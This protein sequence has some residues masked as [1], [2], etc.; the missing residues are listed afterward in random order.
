MRPALRSIGW[1]SQD[2]NAQDMQDEKNYRKWLFAFVCWHVPNQNYSNLIAVDSR[3]EQ[4]STKAIYWRILIVANGISKCIALHCVALKQPNLKFA[5]RF[6]CSRAQCVS[7][8][9]TS[10]MVSVCVCGCVYVCAPA[11]NVKF[12]LK[13]IWWNLH[14]NALRCGAL[15]KLK[16][17]LLLILKSFACYQSLLKP[18]PPVFYFSWWTSLGSVARR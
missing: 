18:S 7:T 1:Q 12:S 5:F 17:C 8:T 13:Y 3:T 6:E 11:A 10:K 15:I 14:C 4:T 16:S 2:Q 9:S